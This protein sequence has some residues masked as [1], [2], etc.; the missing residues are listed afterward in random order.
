MP[1]T[2]CEAPHEMAVLAM[3][4]HRLARPASQLAGSE[5]WLADDVYGPAAHAW[6]LAHL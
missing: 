6:V 5:P 3:I 2:G 1:P 4:A